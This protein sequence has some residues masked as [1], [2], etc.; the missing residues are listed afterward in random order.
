MIFR[1]WLIYLGLLL[2][3]LIFACDLFY[4]ASCPSLLFMAGVCVV[5]MLLLLG[6][7][8]I[9]SRVL[10]VAIGLELPVVVLADLPLNQTMISLFCLILVAVMTR[11]LFFG[12]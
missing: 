5:G 9:A 11:R 10:A 8:D 2:L 1:I 3:T 12:N 4:L 7:Q 6:K